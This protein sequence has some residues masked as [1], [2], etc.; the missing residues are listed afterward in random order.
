MSDVAQDA[1]PS[2]SRCGSDRI[3]CDLDLVS[4]GPYGG[5]IVARFNASKSFYAPDTVDGYTVV[6]ACGSCGHIEIRLKHPE[7]VWNQY[8]RVKRR[9]EET[10]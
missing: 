9:N 1:K 4:R 7:R 8:Q 10:S 6:D 5:D 2:C 3:I